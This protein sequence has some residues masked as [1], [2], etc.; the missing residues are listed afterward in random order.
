MEVP[1]ITEKDVPLMCEVLEALTHYPTADWSQ[2]T[3]SGVHEMVYRKYGFRISIVK[4]Q[5]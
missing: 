3:R 4:E 1:L 2:I 5:E